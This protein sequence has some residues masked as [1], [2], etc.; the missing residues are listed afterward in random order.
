MGR[1]QA[2]GELDGDRKGLVARQPSGA[3][4]VGQRVALQQLHREEEH[5]LCE[6]AM[7]ADLEDAADIRMRDLP[8]DRDLLVKSL[9][10]RSR[11]RQDR[12]AVS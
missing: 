9:Q 3:D 10:E 8:G 1:L 5:R 6:R 11:H 12:R 2:F 7:D 4:A